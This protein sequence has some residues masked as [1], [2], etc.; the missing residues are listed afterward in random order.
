[1]CFV[2]AVG[3]DYTMLSSDIASARAAAEL[4]GL[5]AAPYKEI[6]I[7]DR[8]SYIEGSPLLGPGSHDVSFA[9]GQTSPVTIDVI[10]L[11]GN[12]ITTVVD[13]EQFQAG[14][15]T[16]TMNLPNIAQGTYFLRMT[17]FASSVI[18]G[19]GVVR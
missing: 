12:P 3:E 7:E 9:V 10:D 4:M 8:I 5:N 15:Y 18:E 11:F 17:T 2:I 14:T 16:R 1:M 19:F 6:P 13:N